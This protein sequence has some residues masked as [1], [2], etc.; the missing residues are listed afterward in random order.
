M[1]FLSTHSEFR[2]EVLSAYL[3]IC[4]P[5]YLG[6][7]TLLAQNNLSPSAKECLKPYFNKSMHKEVS[8]PVFIKEF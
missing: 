6:K 3:K 2:F 1:D 4:D 7:S 5:F 8:K